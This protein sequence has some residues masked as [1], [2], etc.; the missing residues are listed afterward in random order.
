MANVVEVKIRGIDEISRVFQSITKTADKSF[1]SIESAIESIP[2]PDINASQ[3]VGQLDNIEKNVNEVEGAIESIPDPKISGSKAEKGLGRIEGTAKQ[4]ENAVKSIPDPKIDGNKASKELDKVKDKV[5]NLKDAIGEINFESVAGAMVAGGG[6]A[7]AIEKS[8]DLSS[9]ETQIDVTFNVPPKSVESIKKAVKGIQS[10]GLDAEEALE[11]VRRQFALNANASDEANM[12]IIKGA[13][14]IASAYSEIDFTELIQETNEIASELN[15][16][17]EEALGLVNSLLKVGF[18]PGELDIIAEYGQQLTRAG[19]SAEEIQAIMAAGVEKGTWNIDNLLDGLKEGRIRLAEFGQEVDDTTKD[20]LKGTGIS[21]KQL[22]QWG[23]AIAGGGE[24][25]KQAMVEV[26]KALSNVDDET[27]KNL[28]GVQFFGTMWEDQGENIIE[29]LLNAENATVSLKEGTEAVNNTVQAMDNSPAVKMRQAFTDINSALSPLYNGISDV[30]SKVASWASEN[31]KLA[32]T[33]VAVLSV[34]GI[35]M[36]LFFA[37]APIITTVT[38]LVGVMGAGFSA[39]AAPVLIAIG[40]IG[41]LIAIGVTVVS[42]WESIMERLSQIWKS[43]ETV[44]VSTFTAIGNFFAMIWGSIKN[45]TSTVWNTITSFF[46]VVWN[47]IKSVFTTTLNVIKTFISTV[48]SNVKNTISTIWNTIK[49]VFQTVWNTIKNI[50]QTSINAVR[51]VINTVLNV[52]KNIITSIWN[53]I[54]SVTSSVWNI[55]L[56]V[57][58]TVTNGLRSVINSVFN[59][60]KSVITSIWNSIRSITSSVWNGIKGAISGVVNGIRSAVTNGFN[61]VKSGVINVWNKIKSRT[62]SIWNGIKNAVKAPINTIIGF[63]NGMINAIN[64]VQ[65]KIPKIPDWVP[66]IGGKG[67]NTIGFNIPNIPQLATGGVVSEPTLAIVGDAGR[68]NPEIV[69]PKKMIRSIVGDELRKIIG[70]TNSDQKGENSPIEVIVPVYL[71]SR[72][73]ARATAPYIDRELGVIRR[74]VSRANGG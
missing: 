5:E 46:S 34:L 62:S 24:K 42:N 30:V 8:L 36:G 74:N 9:L 16:G 25:G 69:A 53:G 35:L 31:P 29:T 10:Y 51:N 39:I 13:G 45:N 40:V 41:A 65:I 21:A 26:A 27:T 17:N 61:S 60:I 66:V 58:R 72:E 37:I 4:V 32:S 18:P 47:Q 15:V 48:F 7:G 73:I 14:A 56:N 70:D 64:R 71:D 19:Y 44:A 2:D 50:V 67:G 57:I 52:I 38:A 12:K 23:Q 54:K 63:I 28:L 68:G 55:I 59:T 6:I 43:I 1:S 33:I 49:N 3:I 20:L 11:G 22:Q